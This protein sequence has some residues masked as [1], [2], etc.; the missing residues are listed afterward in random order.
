VRER[1]KQ[2]M[3]LKEEIERSVDIDEEGKKA[4]K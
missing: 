4:V 3:C 1:E 2:R